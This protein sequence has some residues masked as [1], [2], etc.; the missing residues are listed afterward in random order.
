MGQGFRKD[1][2]KWN[3]ESM[4]KIN[5]GWEEKAHFIWDWKEKSIKC[6]CMYVYSTKSLWMTGNR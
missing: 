5:L 2:L 6:E 3:S 4:Q 1:K